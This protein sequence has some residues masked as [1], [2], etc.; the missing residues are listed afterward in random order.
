M[1]IF[2]K[3]NIISNEWVICSNMDTTGNHYVKSNMLDRVRYYHMISLTDEMEIWAQKLSEKNSEFIS[4][5]SRVVRNTE[6]DKY[7]VIVG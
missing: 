4:T 1:S 7:Y 3:T 6:R 5:E 2:L